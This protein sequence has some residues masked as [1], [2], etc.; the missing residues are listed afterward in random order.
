MAE[1]QEI[2]KP[3]TRDQYNRLKWV[4]NPI[5][6]NPSAMWHRPRPPRRLYREDRRTRVIILIVEGTRVAR[7]I[8]SP[9]LFC[10][11]GD[12]CLGSPD[13]PDHRISSPF[14]SQASSISRV[15]ASGEN[16]TPRR[17]LIRHQSPQ[18]PRES[19]ACT[20]SVLTIEEHLRPPTRLQT[21]QNEK[22]ENRDKNIKKLNSKSLGA[23]NRRDQVVK[24]LHPP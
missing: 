17:D 6:R 9:P 5:L 15:T 12:T 10:N 13:T 2:T 22:L 16:Q 21:N 24:T 23:A 3:T 1:A 19:F 7:T 8:K 11:T 14:W 4:S 20:T 18:H